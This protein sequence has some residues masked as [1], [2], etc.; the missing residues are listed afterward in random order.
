MTSHG[1]LS[2][3]KALPAM[4]RPGTSGA[5]RRADGEAAVT[6]SIRPPSFVSSTAS[7]TKIR[8]QVYRPACPRSSRTLCAI[9]LL[10]IGLVE[11]RFTPRQKQALPRAGAERMRAFRGK[12]GGHHRRRYRHGTRAG[13][14]ADA[15]R[16]VTSRSATSRPRTWPRPKRLCE[17]R[18]P[19]ACASARTCATSSDER[20]VL[21]FRDAV[22]A[23]H[24]TDHI[25]LLFN[26]AG[27]G[28]GGSFLND[29]RAEWERDLRRLL[30]RRL[31]LHAR[32]PAAAGGERRGLHRQHQQRERLLGLPRAEHARTPPTA[33]PSSP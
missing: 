13:G 22:K 14:A 30:V 1:S 4:G 2:S 7:R 12:I 18:R 32:L 25:N 8:L 5:I 9:G 29:D 16:A 15:P 3:S 33:P 20:Q 26:N 27:I 10:L 19:P 24:A 17:A 23:Q 21:A 11:A 31:L 6:S 28:G